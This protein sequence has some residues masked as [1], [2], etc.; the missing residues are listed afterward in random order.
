[1]KHL[2]KF[3]LLCAIAVVATACP[4]PEPTPGQEKGSLKL[5]Q[6]MLLEDL[7][8]GLAHY[9]FTFTTDSLTADAEGEFAGS[10]NYIVLHLI[11]SD[12]NLFPKTGTYNVV[13]G[14]EEGVLGS[15]QGQAMSGYY[16]VTNGVAGGNMIAFNDGTLKVEGTAANATITLNFTAENGQKIEGVYKGA[17]NV[18]D[19]RKNGGDE[20]DAFSYETDEN[21]TVALNGVQAAVQVQNGQFMLM[22][23]AADGFTLMALG[24]SQEGD[25]PYYGTFTVAEEPQAG[26]ILAST[27]YSAEGV[28]PSICC[29]M[30]AQGEIDGSQP[31]YFVRGGS[32]VIAEGSISGALTTAKNNTINVSFS[33]DIQEVTGQQ[34]RIKAKVNPFTGRTLISVK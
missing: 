17:L 12:N 20:G 3:A 28:A 2:M 30:T 4:G 14:I 13:S 16:V 22:V 10:G 15:Y 23:Q 11:A 7:N 26:Q 8:G 21:Q 18:E 34:N 27:G 32:L 5:D 19:T 24:V 31:L 33:G 6:A 29:Y 1:M 9:G 25:Q